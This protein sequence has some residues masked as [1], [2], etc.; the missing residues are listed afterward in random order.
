VD[1]IYHLRLVRLLLA[2]MTTIAAARLTAA[3]VVPELRAED[4][5]DFWRVGLS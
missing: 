4:V 3:V 2:M 5:L 1:Y